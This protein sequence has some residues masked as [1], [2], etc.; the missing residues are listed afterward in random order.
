MGILSS[1]RKVIEKSK[2]V[3]PVLPPT[4]KEGLELAEVGVIIAER[5]SKK[6]PSEKK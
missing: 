2:K 3:S 1:I 6:K 5:F 4:V